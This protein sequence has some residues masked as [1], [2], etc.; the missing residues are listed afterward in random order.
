MS[1]LEFSGLG[2]FDPF[3]D[4]KKEDKSKNSV[5]DEAVHIRIQQR[6]GKKYA[7]VQ[8]PCACCPVLRSW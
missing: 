3:A 5:A 6:N 4:A 7:A 8:L 2:G 1:D